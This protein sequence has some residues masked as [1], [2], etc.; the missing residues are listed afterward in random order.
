MDVLGLLGAAL[1][2]FTLGL[3]GG[4]GSI[5]AVPI[6]VYIYGLSGSVA[7][8]YSLLIVGISA[9]IGTL[10]YARKGFV[11]YKVGITFF[12]PSMVGV[13]I[14]RKLLLPLIP[15]S[16]SFLGHVVTKD[17]IILI[18]FAAV[19]VSAAWSMLKSET[20]K[21]G[22]FLNSKSHLK[23]IKMGFLVGLTTG[24]VGAGGGFLIIPALVSG[25]QI[26][27]HRAVA[28][29][30]MI[31]ALNSMLGF[32]SDLLFALSVQ[33]PIDWNILLP[34]LGVALFGMGIG[35]VLNPYIPT[36]KL[37]RIFGWTV[38]ILGAFVLFKQLQV[39]FA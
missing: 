6:L 23:T 34:F 31:I 19:M 38:L 8:Y 33:N 12:I 9:G 35:T 20:Q 21:S 29:S 14:A 30:L 5:L 13:L 10:P 28:T 2:G 24:F 36:Q 22:I 15:D 3:L 25:L 7:T 27:V 32:A 1:M 37:K 17:F 11:D 16:F 26:P 4:G 18:S 39:F